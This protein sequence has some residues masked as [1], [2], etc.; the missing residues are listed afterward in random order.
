[1]QAVGLVDHPGI[2]KL[3]KDGLNGAREAIVKRKA[4]ARPIDRVS[5]RLHLGRDGFAVL[6][7]PLPDLVDELFAF[8]IPARLAFGLLQA[9]FDLGL[10]GNARVVIAWQPQR[11]VALHAL[12]AD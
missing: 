2:E 5:D 4:F 9:R 12:A 11:G 10:R 6:I 3:L 8:I 7:L 1:N